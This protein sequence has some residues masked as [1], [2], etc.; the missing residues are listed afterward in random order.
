M[1]VACKHSCDHVTQAVTKELEALH[2]PPSCVSDP[3]PDDD[4]SAD[5]VKEKWIDRS[6]AF[7]LLLSAAG[8]ESNPGQCP[9]SLKQQV[10]N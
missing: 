7:G 4:A 8:I 3:D 6:G 5:Q 2:Q 9:P 10:T 1:Q